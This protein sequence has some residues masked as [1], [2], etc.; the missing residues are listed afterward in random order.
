[1]GETCVS[2]SRAATRLRAVPSCAYSSYLRGVV[3]GHLGQDEQC[4]AS[5]AAAVRGEPLLWC[6]WYE[7][8]KHLSTEK[9]RDILSTL[10]NMDMRIAALGLPTHHWVYP[11]FAS[12]LLAELQCFE[13]AVAATDALLLACPGNAFARTQ[14]ALLAYNMRNFE[15]REAVWFLVFLFFFD[16]D[17][18]FFFPASE[19][20]FEA[21]WRDDP[22]RISDMDIYSNV[23]YVRGAKP[24]LSYLAHRVSKTDRLRPES[25]CIVGNYYSMRGDHNK[26]LSYFMRAL[27]LHPGFLSALTLMGHEYMELSN[28]QSAVHCYRRAVELNERDFRAW[29][30]LGQAYEILGM[31]EFAMWYFQK[32]CSLR[33][34][35][36]RMW[37]ALGECFDKV[38]R[39]ADAI[40]AFERAVASNDVEGI[41]LRSLAKLHD[42]QR[43]PERAAYFYRA[44]LEAMDSKGIEGPATVEAL[45]YLAKHSAS[46]VHC[47]CCCAVVV[48]E[49][50]FSRPCGRMQR[51]TASACLTLQCPRRRMPRAFSRR[52]T[53]GNNFNN[54]RCRYTKFQ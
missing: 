52:Y 8:A 41:A 19:A 31:N 44:H 5:L 6:A 27:R 13:E 18:S 35:D 38:Q 34:H 3:H 20:A 22:Y 53:S 7:L 49:L 15:G 4:V 12:H 16:I 47:S 33:P 17:V 25:C 37:V 36:A 43:N 48:A 24:K 30:A 40:H 51:V 10:A 2:Q 50:F 32:A 28:A 26:A 42:R 11:F 21:I 9:A 23:L 1:M 54:S 14:K 45:W 29:Y 46:K 39:P